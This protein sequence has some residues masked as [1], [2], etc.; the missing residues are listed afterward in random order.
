[1]VL[2][3]CIGL[4]FR[5]C[6]SIQYGQTSSNVINQNAF[7]G[8]KLA[9]DD[10]LSLSLSLWISLSILFRKLKLVRRTEWHTSSDSSLSA[11]VRVQRQAVRL[12]QLHS[13][14]TCTDNYLNCFNTVRV[15]RWTEGECLG[16]GWREYEDPSKPTGPH[17][18]RPHTIGTV[19]STSTTVCTICSTRWRYN[20]IS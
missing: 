8:H 6:L 3:D 12:R 17:A 18:D 15:V 19:L 10:S 13:F 7:L 20:R 14:N 16:A 9:V 11:N 4:P 2:Q 1:M 5:P